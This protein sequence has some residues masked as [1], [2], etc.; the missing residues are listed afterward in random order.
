MNCPKCNKENYP[1]GSGTHEVFATEYE[2]KCECGHGWVSLQNNTKPVG[3]FE[4]TMLAFDR[5]F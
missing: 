3:A 2:Y 4:E 1:T 5:I